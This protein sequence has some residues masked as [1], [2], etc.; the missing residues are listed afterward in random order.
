MHQAPSRSFTFGKSHF[1][2]HVKDGSAGKKAVNFMPAILFISVAAGSYFSLTLM[3]NQFHKIECEAVKSPLNEQ[4][5]FEG[6][7]HF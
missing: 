3:N 6:K 2:K 4:A 1:N 7:L 5:A